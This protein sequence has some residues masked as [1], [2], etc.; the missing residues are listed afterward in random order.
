MSVGSLGSRAG[1]GLE[2]PLLPLA[3]G[4]GGS[5]GVAEIERVLPVR[6]WAGWGS[7]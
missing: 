4:D 2:G 1:L 7:P 3:A 5:A 6:P